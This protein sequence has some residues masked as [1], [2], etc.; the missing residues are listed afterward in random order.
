MHYF[1][2][3]ASYTYQ[4][5]SETAQKIA[6]GL[7]KSNPNTWKELLADHEEHKAIFSLMKERATK[8]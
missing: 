8:R 5:M 6:I 1:N 7:I 4:E 3:Y 2:K